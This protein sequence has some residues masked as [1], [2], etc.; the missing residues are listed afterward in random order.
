MDRGAWPA[1][2]DFFVYSLF[3]I[4]FLSMSK[5]KLR[6]IVGTRE[7]WHAAVPGGCKESDMT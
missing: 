6:E 3:S 2:L 1:T 5:S 4:F 7:A